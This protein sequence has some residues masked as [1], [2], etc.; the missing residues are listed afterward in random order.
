M[1]REDDA[2]KFPYVNS[3]C[4]GAFPREIWKSVKYGSL[5]PRKEVSTIFKKLRAISM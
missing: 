2:L 4:L 1:K 3:R 5:R